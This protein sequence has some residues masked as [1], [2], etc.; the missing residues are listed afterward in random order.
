MGSIG[1]LGAARRRLFHAYDQARA[2][3][4]R[5]GSV[6]M[7]ELA[8]AEQAYQQARLF[9]DCARAVDAPDLGVADL[10]RTGSISVSA[11]HPAKIDCAQRDAGQRPRGGMA[12]QPGDRN[13]PPRRPSC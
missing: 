2:V 5:P 9:D 10:D 8:A 11:S 1:E 12:G 7:R 13:A 3:G 6:Q 4:Y